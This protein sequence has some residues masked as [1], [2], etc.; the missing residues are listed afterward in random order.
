[1]SLSNWGS[2]FVRQSMMGLKERVNLWFKPE[3]WVECMADEVLMIGLFSVKCL[4]NNRAFTLGP[5]NHPRL[6]CYSL[7]SDCVALS[8]QNRS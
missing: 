6:L 7:Y 1:M 4:V 3:S 2:D 8:S 5:I